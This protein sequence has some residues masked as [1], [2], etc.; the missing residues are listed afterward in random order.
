MVAEFPVQQAVEAGLGV[1]TDPVAREDVGVDLEAEF[2][3]EVK[4][5]RG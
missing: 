3:W 4:E 2:G 5:L 1:E